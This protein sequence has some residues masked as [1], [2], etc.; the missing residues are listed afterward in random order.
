MKGSLKIIS[1]LFFGF[2]SQISFSQDT[3][4][5][6]FKIK[7]IYATAAGITG[8]RIDRTEL[9]DSGGIMLHGCDSCYVLGFKI[10]GKCTKS[11]IID[12]ITTTILV[13]TNVDSISRTVDPRW[14][15]NVFLSKNDRFTLPMKKYIWNTN[16][17]YLPYYIEITD[18]TVVKPGGEEV[19][20]DKLCFYF[21]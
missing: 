21:K 8:G 16:N 12:S 20:L 3:A 5:N 2:S 9:I 14:A 11:P 10:T 4:T 1:L 19:T 17:F 7:K 15:K 13:N 6:I 18:I